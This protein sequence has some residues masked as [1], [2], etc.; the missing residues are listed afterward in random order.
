MRP[1]KVIQADTDHVHGEL[2]CLH[3]S[4]STVAAN[5]LPPSKPD[6]EWT[7]EAFHPVTM[8]E[9]GLFYHHQDTLVSGCKLAARNGLK[10]FPDDDL[11]HP[12][13]RPALELCL[14]TAG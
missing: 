2:E 4:G 12:A 3:H 1:G 9:L 5:F 13:C 6:R 10:N 7:T 11:S 8:E 14:V